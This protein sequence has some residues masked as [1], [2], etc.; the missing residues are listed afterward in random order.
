MGRLAFIKRPRV[1]IPIVILLLIAA[2][3][4]LVVKNMTAPAVGSINQAPPAQSATTEPYTQPGK[5]SGQYVSF[6]YPAHF[7][8]V[9]SKLTGSFL[10][11]VDYH[12]TD[13]AGKQINVGV[14][15][16]AVDSDSSISY[17]RQHKDSYTET[18][19]QKWI[20]FS[21][22]DGTEDTFYLEHGDLLASVS[23]TAPSGGLNGEALFVASGLKWKVG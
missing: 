21:K 10:E 22:K 7:K 15:K 20:E 6:S 3:V 14:Y 16:S 23:A 2:V 17:R 9:P 4:F 5:Y 13:L 12:S 11:T 8:K 1:F 19:S 18:D